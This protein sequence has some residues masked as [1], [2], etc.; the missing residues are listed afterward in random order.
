MSFRFFDFLP[1]LIAR[2]NQWFSANNVPLE[3]IL[4]T[5]LIAN[6]VWVSLVDTPKVD[7]VNCTYWRPQACVV[8]EIWGKLRSEQ[9]C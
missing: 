7:H 5:A 1:R 2:C 3:L 9:A 8:H 6:G 4:P